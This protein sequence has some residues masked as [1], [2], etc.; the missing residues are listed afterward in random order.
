LSVEGLSHAKCDYLSRVLK[1]THAQDCEWAAEYKILGYELITTMNDAKHSLAMYIRHGLKDVSVLE[2][3]KA[4]GISIVV[5]RIRQLTIT[6][7]YRPPNLEWPKPALPS[8]PHPAVYLG[9]FNSNHSQWGYSKNDAAV[10]QLTDLA[11]FT[12]VH[13]LFDP[14]QPSTFCSARWNTEHNPDL[15]FLTKENSGVPLQASRTVLGNFPCSQHHPTIMHVG[16]GAPLIE[17]TPKL[18]KNFCKA[19]WVAYTAK[20]EDEIHRIKSIPENDCF[21]DLLIKAAMKHI[22]HNYHKVYTP[23]WQPETEALFKEYEKSSDP[24]TAKV[25]LES[26][27]SAC[28]K[29]W[30][31]TVEGL[32]FIHSSCKTWAL[33]HKLGAADLVKHHEPKVTANAVAS[34]LFHNSKTKTNKLTRQKVQKELFLNV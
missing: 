32:D 20:V 10:E 4:M 5:I 24:D 26:L 34:H 8:F 23:C 25:L 6:N 33:L 29:R 9:D 15:C 31:E 30:N 21:I 14:K 19:N 3:S 28:L 13:L 7:V 12:D 17:S 22:P 2:E 16:F 18:C 27:S 11:S 1:E